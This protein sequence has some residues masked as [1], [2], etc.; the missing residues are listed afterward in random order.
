VVVIEGGVAIGIDETRTTLATGLLAR[1]NHTG[2]QAHTTITG[3]GTAAV[4]ATGDFATAAQGTLAASA[5]QT[6][7]AIA[8]VSGLQAAIDGRQP[9][10]S[11]LTDISALVNPASA[12]ILSESSAGVWSFLPTS[13]FATAAQGT[14]ASSALQ[15]GTAI[16]TVA[17]LQNALDGKQA[18]GSYATAAQGALADTALQPSG[19]LAGLAS[20]TTARTN[21]GLGTAATTAASDYA[22]A[23][24]GTIATSALQSGAAIGTIAGLQTA[25][26]GKQASGSYATG[27]QGTLADSALQRIRQT[28][29][30][31]DVTVNATATQLAQT[32]TMTAARTVTLPL[33]NS[34]AA[35]FVLDIV[36]ES[37]TTSSTNKIILARA[38]SNLINGVTTLDAITL[39]N[40]AVYCVSDGSTK[41]SVF[42]SR[43]LA[44]GWVRHTDWLAMPAVGS[45]E[46]K[47]VGLFAVT[48]DASNYLALLFAGNYNVDWGDGTN[49]NVAANV[50]A[51]KLYDYATISAATESSRGYRQVLVMVT[52]QA[53]HNLTLMNLQQRHSRFAG[54][55][56]NTAWLDIT[57][58]GA[59]FTSL[60]LGGTEVLLALVERVN[61][62]T[63]GTL[64][65]VSALFRNCRS[66]QSVTLFNTASVTDFSVMYLSCTSIQTFPLLNTASGTNFSSMYN[67]CSSAQTFPTH[68]TASG[69]NFS[70]MYNSCPAA[71]TFPTHNTAAGTNF[72]SMYSNCS[73]ARAFPPIDT[74][75]GTIFE[76]MYQ[77]CTTVQIFPSLNTAAGTNFLFMYSNCPAAQTFPTLNT[78]LGTTFSSMYNGCISG[79]SVGITGSRFAISFA[80]MKLSRQAI[81]D[82]F[83][84]LGTASGAQTVTVTGN[85]GVP[86]LT[87]A[88]LLIATNKGWTVAS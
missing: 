83:T 17:G 63:V 37:G 29:S 38:G 27:A 66:L 84:A 79:A 1:A 7:T 71:Q 9:L 64:T 58:N 61:I 3:L 44:P 55:F 16:S 87:A 25:L 72:S 53:G 48:N 8:N 15:T 42:F 22:T 2:T 23:A 35:G 12:S 81:A 6:G 20:T 30:N 26:D 54:G 21:L 59:N 76:F 47:F 14:L 52:P 5:L 36:D 45:G 18:L 77:N 40:G 62:Q 51:E 49:E 82:I 19:N 70:S 56:R 85:H 24:Q 74:S 46:Q 31:A 39:A 65:S 41:W 57:L 80:S 28:F 4:S 32:G 73:A 86:D 11:D 88:D 68:N 75:L 50:R 60:T 13:N 67:G 10:D 69:T 34:K 43:G 33:A 78:S